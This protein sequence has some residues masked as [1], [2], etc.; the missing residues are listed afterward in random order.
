MLWVNFQHV[1]NVILHVNLVSKIRQNKDSLFLFYYLNWT[2]VQAEQID[3]NKI[4]T[5]KY[6]VHMAQWF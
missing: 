4:K 3:N 2:K 6:T 1:G 5:Y